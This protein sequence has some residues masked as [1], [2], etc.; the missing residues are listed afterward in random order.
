LLFELGEESRFLAKLNSLRART[1]QDEGIKT[2]F[3]LVVKILNDC[4]RSQSA[5][6]GNSIDW[7]GH[8]SKL[9]AILAQFKPLK[10]LGVHELSVWVQSKALGIPIEDAMAHDASFSFPRTIADDVHV[11]EIEKEVLNT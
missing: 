5:N 2:Y 3:K 4:Y 9:Q 8:V 6:T 10:H 11:A 1:I 7:A